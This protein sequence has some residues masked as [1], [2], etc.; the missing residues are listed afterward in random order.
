M[1]DY[2]TL[3]ID[4][5]TAREIRNRKAELMRME[6]RLK[7]VED[8]LTEVYNAPGMPGYIK[9]KTRFEEELCRVSTEIC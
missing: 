5:S 9:A 7:R 6:D 8:M 1:W 4:T 3:R 2:V